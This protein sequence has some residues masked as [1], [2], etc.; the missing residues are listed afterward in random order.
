MANPDEGEV[1]F[2]VKGTNYTLSYPNRT[3]RAIE[4]RLKRPIGKV[5]RDLQEGASTEEIVAIFFLGLHRHHP[6]LTEE[7]A[8]DLLLM[9]EV[10]RL[11]TDGLSLAMGS[12]EPA[13]APAADGDSGARPQ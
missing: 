12:S 3:L 1:G 9:G 5:L 4:K 8:E 2:S 6:D 11:V 7:Q 13:D 10:M